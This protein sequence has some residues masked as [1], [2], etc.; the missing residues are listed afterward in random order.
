MKKRLTAEQARNIRA[1]S[2]PA[3]AVATDYGIGLQH[4]YDIRI[5]RKWKNA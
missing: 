3:N 5:G 4:V 1:D 2:R